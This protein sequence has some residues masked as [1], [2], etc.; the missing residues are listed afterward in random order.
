MEENRSTFKLSGQEK[1][2]LVWHYLRP[3]W[4]HF[5]AALLCACLSMALNALTPQIIRITVDSI[6]GSEEAKLPAL[7][8][9]VLPLETLRQEPVTA[10]WWAAGAVMVTALLR[11][12]CSFGQRA[13]LSRGSEAYVKGLRDDLYRRIQYL[14]FAWHKQHPTGDIIQRCTSDVDVIR[15]FVCNQLVE[16]VRTVFLIILYLWIMFR[17]NVK[18]SLIALAFIPIVGLSSGV[19]YRK[20]SSRFKTADEA[21]GEVTTCAQE[22]LTAVRVVRAFGREKYE[23]DKFQAKSERYAGLW[24]H[25]GKLLS[26]YWASGTLL[27]CLQVMVIILAG[28]HESVAGAMTL[29]AFV[30]FVSYN[31]SLAWPVR[32][33]GRVLSDMSKAGV[34]MD[35]VGYILRSPEEQDQPD[36]VPFPGG[37]IVFDHVTFG[38][39]G[40]PVL[41]DVSFTIRE[42]ETF[43]VLGGTGSGKT[44]LTRHLKEHFGDAVTVIGHDSY[45]KRQDGKTYEERS[46]VNYDHPDAFETS[47]LVEHLKALKAGRS[48]QCPVY[49]YVDHNRTDET[50]EVF[51][52]K[53]IIV[54]GI[55]IF[56]DPTLR[57]MFDIKIFVETDADVRILRRALRDIRDRGR[58]LESVITQYLTTVKPMHEQYVEPSRK[59]ADIIVLE[60]GH[61]LVA[62]DMIMQR[63]ASHI[64]SE[65]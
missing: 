50:V 51:P 44:T 5:A 37:D 24:I 42:G 33:L 8:L 12:L 34:S 45:Y 30:A 62:L 17:M 40:Q 2:G 57:D 23:E 32:S 22:N 29:G 10:L 1:A 52:T 35:R 49:S 25:L 20:I 41:K 7:L 11:G 16:V 6:L 3:C 58:T 64:A 43:P 21:E 9:R 46:K 54:E 38:Y 65:D 4:G 39:E 63:I 27:T 14:P 26:V 13:Q 47:L 56:Q 55:L 59:Y 48:I 31:E 28:I 15:T 19:F 36:D 61:N 53:V 18:L 60:G